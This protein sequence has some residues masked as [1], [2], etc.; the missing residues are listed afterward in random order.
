MAATNEKHEALYQEV[1]AV[2]RK[3]DLPN[4]EILAVFANMTGKVLAM[5]DQTVGDANFYMKIVA[6]NLELGNKQVLEALFGEVGGR[7]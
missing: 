4:V 6:K 5:Q 1:L 7:A 2:V 3:Y